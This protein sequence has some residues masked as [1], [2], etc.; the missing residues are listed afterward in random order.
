M[1]IAGEAVEAAHVAGMLA[2]EELVEEPMLVA[3]WLE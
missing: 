2:H 3:V 1:G